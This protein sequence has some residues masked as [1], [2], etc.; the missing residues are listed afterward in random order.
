MMEVKHIIWGTAYVSKQGFA[1]EN[2]LNEANFQ[3][4]KFVVVDSE[5]AGEYKVVFVKEEL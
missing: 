5:L 2:F 3:P 1:L 4:G